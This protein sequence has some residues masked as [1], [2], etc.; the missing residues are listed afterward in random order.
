MRPTPGISTCVTDAPALLHTSRS[1]IA[2]MPG[3]TADMMLLC[4]TKVLRLQQCSSELVEPRP[5]RCFRR[6]RIFANT[7]KANAP[8]LPD[9]IRYRA[10]SMT[11]S[12]SNAMLHP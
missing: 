6:N 12:A 2:V 3:H 11:F 5:E 9:G 4:R 7:H 8:T 1:W 10:A